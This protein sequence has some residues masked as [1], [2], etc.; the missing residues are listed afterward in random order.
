MLES[1]RNCPLTPVYRSF[2]DVT[3]FKDYEIT[4]LLSTRYFSTKNSKND[5]VISPSLK[6]SFNLAL[7]I[8]IT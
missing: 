5:K 1:W 7:K 8:T 3:Y 6:E 4:T 2:L